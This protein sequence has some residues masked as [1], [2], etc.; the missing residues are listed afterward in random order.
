MAV[1]VA[2]GAGVLCVE[3]PGVGVGVGFVPGALDALPVGARFAP[4]D[5]LQP[6]KLA[7]ASIR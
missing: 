1:G 4:D 6:A 5:E 3:L 2:V 7:H